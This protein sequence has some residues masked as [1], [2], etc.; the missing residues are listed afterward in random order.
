MPKTTPPQHTKALASWPLCSNTAGKTSR[1]GNTGGAD[2]RAGVGCW[3]LHRPHT[4]LEVCSVPTPTRPGS[5]PSTSVN[6]TTSSE[7]ARTA[8]P[9]SSPAGSPLCNRAILSS[10]GPSSPPQVCPLLPGAQGRLQEAGGGG[11][12]LGSWSLQPALGKHPAQQHPAPQS[13]SQGQH[14]IQQ[15]VRSGASVGDSVCPWWGARRPLFLCPTLGGG[16]GRQGWPTIVQGCTSFA[17]ASQQ[18]E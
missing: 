14:Y 13:S 17:K 1:R 11:D 16:V 8:L 4:D 9:S 2:S 6:G 7:W 18:P 12:H 15:G 5:E 3:V 10:M